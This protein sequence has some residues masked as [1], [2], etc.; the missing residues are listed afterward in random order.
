MPN[1]L[2]YILLADDNE[3]DLEL[4]QRALAEYKLANEIVVVQD[5]AEALDFL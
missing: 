5:G 4:T 2:G 1:K 3:N